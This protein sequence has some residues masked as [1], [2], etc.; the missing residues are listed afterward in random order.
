ML[1]A[2]VVLLRAA[3]SGLAAGFAQMQTSLQAAD[4]EWNT[5]RQLQLSK[6]TPQ[7][8]VSLRRLPLRG[9]RQAQAAGQPAR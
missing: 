9:L 6:A 3:A 4:R 1:H 7:R 8:V 2:C 5:C